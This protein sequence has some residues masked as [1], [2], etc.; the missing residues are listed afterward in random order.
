MALPVW[1]PPDTRILSR[2]RNLEE[3]RR[4]RR[5]RA[6]ADEVGGVDHE[7]ADVHRPSK[8]SLLEGWGERAAHTISAYERSISSE[9][10]MP[11]SSTYSNPLPQRGDWK[12]V[13]RR[14][15]RKVAPGGHYLSELSLGCRSSWVP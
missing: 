4:L 14:V 15:A 5:D 6:E 7:L 12:I 9:T 10:R 13:I 2:R 1:V 3:P 11:R 8:T